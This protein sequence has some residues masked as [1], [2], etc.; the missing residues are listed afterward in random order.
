MIK[1]NKIKYIKKKDKEKKGRKP[2]S[3]CKVALRSFKSLTQK[4][5][6][7]LKTPQHF[8]LQALSH[9]TKCTIFFIDPTPREVPSD[10]LNH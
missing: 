4:K 7:S 6:N 5:I 8:S 2:W 1:K 3:W 9:C 10:L